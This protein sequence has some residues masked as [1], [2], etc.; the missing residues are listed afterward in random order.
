LLLADIMSS[1]ASAKALSETGDSEKLLRVE[2]Q[3]DDAVA[4]STELQ[5]QISMMREQHRS[6]LSVI[7]AEQ[8][9]SSSTH[10]GTVTALHERI[11]WWEDT[12]KS[13]AAEHTARLLNTVAERDAKQLSL[14]ASESN[15]TDA[16]ETVEK[17]LLREEI[18]KSKSVAH[19]VMQSAEHSVLLEPDITR[20][21]VCPLS[22]KF[23][24]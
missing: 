15:L 16:R 8:Q 14:T 11:K 20:I 5:A 1:Q 18:L 4:C 12:Y 22:I 7:H 3:L 24:H 13:Q 17:I 21:V 9:I 2:K 23:T 6:S 10:L 19:S